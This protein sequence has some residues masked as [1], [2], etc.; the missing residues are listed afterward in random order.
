MSGLKDKVSGAFDDAMESLNDKKKDAGH[1]F[2]EE[3]GRIQQRSSD[4]QEDRSDGTNWSD[5][6]VPKQPE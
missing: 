5:D 3:K 4:K 2:Y 6:S 1:K